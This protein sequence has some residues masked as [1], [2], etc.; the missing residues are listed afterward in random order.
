MAQRRF[1][2]GQVRVITQEQA[3]KYKAVH[4]GFGWAGRTAISG[5]G[6]NTLR[7]A[8]E[9]E[10]SPELDQ[11]AED[12]I[13]KGIETLLVRIFEILPEKMEKASLKDLSVAMGI[14]LDKHL[15]YKGKPNN[16]TRSDINTK[17]LSWKH[18]VNEKLTGDDKQN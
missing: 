3:A 5:I 14:L 10:T 16:V 18:I 15:V 6:V 9:M 13:I 8:L 11:Q 7:R 1:K 12:Q 17:E 4:K 2:K